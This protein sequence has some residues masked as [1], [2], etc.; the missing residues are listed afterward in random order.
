MIDRRTLLGGLALA[1]F[2][3]PL[4]AVPTAPAYGARG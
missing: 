1:I 3:A 4:D 2:A